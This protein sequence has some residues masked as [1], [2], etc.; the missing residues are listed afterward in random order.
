GFSLYDVLADGRPVTGIERI[1]PVLVGVQLALSA[2]WRSYGVVPDAVIGHS[3]GEVSAA[4]VAGI[5][6]PAQGLA[7][8]STRS[9]LLAGL[10]GRG[11]MALLELDVEATQDLL[12]DHRDVAIAV[13]ACPR[14]TV[15]AGPPDQI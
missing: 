8:I 4:V 10:A 2:L 11:A 12:T 15:I 1:Q 5:L 9:R 14:Q 13:E 3:M 7:V 6:T